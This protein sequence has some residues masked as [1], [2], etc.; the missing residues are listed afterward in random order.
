MGNQVKCAG[1][2]L[3]GGES[4]RFGSPKALAEWKGRTFI[5]Y[6]IKSL[7]P[8]AD[9]IIVVTREELLKPLTRYSS[10]NIRILTDATRFKSK[11]PLAGIYTAMIS[12]KADYYLVSPCD[13]PL[14]NSSMY[15]MW[16]AHVQEEDYGC[17]IP[18]LDG[19]IYPLNGVY[20]KTCLPDITL[21]LHKNIYKVLKLLQRKNTKYI[22]VQKEERHLFRNVNTPNELSVLEDREEN[23]PGRIFQ[24]M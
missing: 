2:V 22:E 3:A 1:I 5:D 12:Q 16:L 13:M 4:Q 6:S 9:N 7:A 23:E 20:N 14:M 24:E 8:F 17:V 18:V 21:C 11:G 15:K 19:R 10:Q